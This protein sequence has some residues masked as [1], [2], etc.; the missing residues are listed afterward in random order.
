MF[1]F[2]LSWPFLLPSSQTRSSPRL[3]SGETSGLSSLGRMVGVHPPHPLRNATLNI[4]VLRA[5]SKDV[6]LILSPRLSELPLGGQST[7]CSRVRPKNKDGNC[8]FQASA[9]LW[10]SRANSR[11]PIAA[12]TWVC[13]SSSPDCLGGL[14]VCVRL[15]LDTASGC[16]GASSELSK[17]PGRRM[18]S[19]LSKNSPALGCSQPPGS[20]C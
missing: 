3:S 13:G 10:V 14:R 1:P 7:G 2:L 20:C 16:S 11:L 4:L 15:V 9:P 17:H 12:Q 5:P 19:L 18:S 8:C 6:R